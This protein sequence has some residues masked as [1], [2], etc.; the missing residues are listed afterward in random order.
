M[1]TMLGWTLALLLFLLPFTS[2]L[3]A[4]P[5]I[6]PP[7]PA[8]DTLDD[9]AEMARQKVAP[10]VWQTSERAAA[11]E[12]VPIIITLGEQADLSGIDDVDRDERVRQVVEALQDVANTSQIPLVAFLATQNAQGLSGPVTRFWVFNGLSVSVN[13]A[14]IEALARRPDVA[15]IT[16]NE[17]FQAPSLEAGTS[18]AEPNISAINAPSLWDLGYSG[19]G[20]VVA[21]VDTGVYLNHP[22]LVAQWRGGTNSWYDPYYQHPDTPTDLSGHG[23]QTMGAMVGREAG[24]TAIGVAPDA[25]W[26]AVKIFND[27]GQATTAGIHRRCTPRGEQLL[28]LREPG[29]QPGIPARFAGPAGSQYSACV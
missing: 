1:R 7:V 25:Q 26:I 19:Q 6:A 27:Q 10:A 4:G 21:N 5:G 14:V 23:T 2:T 16:P 28:E 17:V 12:L 20:I 11:A 9:P 15:R 8:S 24:G 29:L 22:D 3:S 18:P 13:A